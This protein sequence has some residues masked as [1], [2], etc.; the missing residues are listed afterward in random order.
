M[1][2]GG[3]RLGIPHGIQSFQWCCRASA[4]CSAMISRIGRAMPLNE[5]A[6]FIRRDAVSVVAGL[7]EF[8]IGFH[9]WLCHGGDLLLKFFWL[10][11]QRVESF[12]IKHDHPIHL[13]PIGRDVLPRVPF[14]EELKEALA[15]LNLICRIFMVIVV[16]TVD[17][18]A[19]IK[20]EF[21]RAA[22]VHISRWLPSL[23]SVQFKHFFD[24][25]RI[26]IIPIALM[27]R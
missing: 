14:L 20:G 17:H 15:I 3:L 27:R 4:T 9:G 22:R 11:D 19:R 26:A 1:L 13:R 25:G 18:I 5:R 16:A 6:Q 10:A 23:I 12:L 7:V 24:A 8:G 2:L 21:F